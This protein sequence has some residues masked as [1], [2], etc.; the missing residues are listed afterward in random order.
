MIKVVNKK[1][2][3]PTDVDIY[4]GRG[5]VLG[6]PYTGTKKLEQTKAKYQSSSRESS[7]D[8]YE[9]YIKKKILDNDRVICDELNKI[10]KMA[11]NGDVNLVCYCSPKPCHGQIIRGI[12]HAEILKRILKDGKESIQDA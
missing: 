9:K 5:S 2:H 1:T 12:I 6:N 11:K 8:D 10:Y 4:I 7:I 3:T